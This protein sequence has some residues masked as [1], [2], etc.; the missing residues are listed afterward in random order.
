MMTYPWLIMLQLHSRSQ[1][2]PPQMKVLKLQAAVLSSKMTGISVGI[3]KNVIIKEYT[4]ACSKKVGLS[5]PV[6]SSN[7]G[8]PTS[9]PTKYLTIAQLVHD[10]QMKPSL[11]HHYQ[12]EDLVLQN[13]IVILL[14]ESDGFLSPIKIKN[15]S[16]VNR[17]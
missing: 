12:V 4:Q 3:D 13:I 17:L 15:L 16:T 6:A 7:K 9:K 5:H 2:R 10:C 14:Q 8:E 1:K 11:D